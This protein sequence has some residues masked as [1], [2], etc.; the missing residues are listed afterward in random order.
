M[1]AARKAGP[2]ASP[3]VHRNRVVRGCGRYSPS[4][5]L[6]EGF[7]GCSPPGG[8]GQVILAG[9]QQ[10]VAS[11]HP[12]FGTCPD[13]S[14]GGRRFPVVRTDKATDVLPARVPES[15]EPAAKPR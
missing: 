3:T 5:S 6:V 10:L 9:N 14:V 7:E 15:G 11:D 12:A 8:A 2:R 4:S 13:L 1:K